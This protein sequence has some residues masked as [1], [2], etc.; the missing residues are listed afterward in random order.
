MHGQSF[1]H[2]FYPGLL[3][4]CKMFCPCPYYHIHIVHTEYLWKQPESS[5]I[6]Y[7]YSAVF[8]VANLAD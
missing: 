4:I 6:Y 3:L 7:E 5:I 1:T 2:T 8:Q